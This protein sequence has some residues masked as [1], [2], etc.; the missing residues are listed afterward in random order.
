MDVSMSLPQAEAYLSLNV[1]I[2]IVRTYSVTI[3]AYLNYR[4]V[5]MLC[6]A[7]P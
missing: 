3:A 5:L 2:E 1:R 4:P 7:Q 6:A